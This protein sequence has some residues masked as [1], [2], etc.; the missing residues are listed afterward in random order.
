MN[1]D[2]V[3]GLSRLS[4]KYGDRLLT[5]L[6]ILLVLMIFVFTPLQA[7]GVAFFQLFGLVSLLAIIAGVLVISASP[8]A[9][10][11]TSIAFA[12]NV[13]VIVFR[14]YW[15]TTYDLAIVTG[16][17]MIIALT[18]GVV[19]A[20]AVFRPGRVTYHRIVGAILLYLLIALTFMLLFAFVGISFPDAFSGLTFEYNSALANKL[21]YFSFVTLTSTGYGDVVPIHP[22]ARSLSN[23]EA[24]I[25]QLYPATLLAR[26]MT[27][28][29]SDRRK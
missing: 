3:K 25:G 16:A 10:A 29:L 23:L 27:L 7:A 13:L 15:P 22:L 26:L 1:I 20:Q 14:L 21:L 17:W 24:I 28:E 2:T 18:L 4:R 9:L 19:V 6:T 8:T 12:A 11:V 5:S